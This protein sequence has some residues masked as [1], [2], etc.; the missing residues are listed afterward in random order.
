MLKALKRR[1][2]RHSF[3]WS[4]RRQMEVCY[5]CGQ[6][7]VAAEPASAPSGATWNAGPG[8]RSQGGGGQA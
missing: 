3:M 7:R 6:A 1:L 8:G 5:H 2:C 4:E